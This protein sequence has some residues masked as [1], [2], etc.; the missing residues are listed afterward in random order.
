MADFS[1]HQE[2]QVVKEVNMLIEQ[3]WS[4]KWELYTDDASNS[5]GTGLALVLKSPQGDTI[6]RLFVVNFLQ[7]TMR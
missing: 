1:P 5:K 2:E 6:V 3:T 4:G 7:L